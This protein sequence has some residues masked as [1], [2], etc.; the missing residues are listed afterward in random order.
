MRLSS[1]Y[2]AVTRNNTEY[3]ITATLAQ[4]KKASEKKRNE[5]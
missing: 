4:D 3:D 2:K 5:A 1:L